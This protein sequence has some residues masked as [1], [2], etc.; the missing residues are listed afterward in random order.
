MS[1]CG[2]VLHLAAPLQAWGEHSAF[3]LRDTA[4][5]PTRSGLIGL[6]A[7]ALGIPRAQAVTDGSDGSD[8]EA[9]F[10]RLTAIRFTVRVDRPGT[11]MSDFHTVGGGYPQHRTVPTAKGGRRSQ[12][13]ATIVSYRH[14]LSDAAFTVAAEVPDDDDLARRCATALA[15]PHWPPHLGRRSCPPGALLLLGTGLADPVAALTGLP[16]ARP[17][18]DG[19][20]VPVRFVGERP[21]PDGTDK[22]P[23]ASG[24]VTVMNDEPVRLTPRDRVYRARPVFSTTRN[25]PASLCAGYGLRYLEA[26][27]PHLG[28]SR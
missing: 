25:L 18:P 27:E 5:Q 10:R 15:A 19:E 26:I 14:Y 24:A 21:F 23:S 8:K 28:V 9:L 13:T 1:G 6:L 12:E 3:T 7:S 16:L 2:F 4:A 11:V 20:T 22:V 17:R